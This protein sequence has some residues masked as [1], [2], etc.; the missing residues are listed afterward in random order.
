MPGYKTHLV[1]G[2]VVYAIGIA[3]LNAVSS[4]H[5]TFVTALGWFFWCILGALFPDIDVKSKGQGF[6]YP[7]ILLA[8]LFF[9]YKSNI[10][11]FMLLSICSLVPLVANHRGLFHNLF[12][13][14]S[15]ALVG[16]LY[17]S[18]FFLSTHFYITQV[19]FFSIGAFSHILLDRYTVAS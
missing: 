5:V 14:I 9:L 4:A 16:A 6:I 19:A 3:L 12:F 13:I 2:V 1:G 7:F 11:E 15:L 8:L 18:N 17:V 10:K